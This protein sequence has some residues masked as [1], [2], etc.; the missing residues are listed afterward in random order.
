M[1]AGLDSALRAWDA[2]A[3]AACARRE[4]LGSSGHTQVLAPYSRTT[5]VAGG[6]IPMPTILSCLIPLVLGSPVLLRETSKD[7]VTASLLARSLSEQNELLGSCFESV[8]FPWHDEA[9]L[10]EAL[11]GGCVVATGRDETLRAISGRLTS[12]QRF[13]G[14]GHR[15]SIGILGPDCFSRVAQQNHEVAHETALDIARWDQ[16]GCLSP[17]VLYLVGMEIEER[18]EF[19]EALSTS[20]DVLGHDLPRGKV[21][22]AAATS[23]TNERASARMRSGSGPDDVMLFEGDAHT[24]ILEA[25]A[26]PRPA[27]LHR[28]V[29][30]LPVDTLADLERRL[31]PFAGRLS[32]VAVAG[33]PNLVPGAPGAEAKG[34][35]PFFE[36]LAALGVSRITEPGQLQTPPIDWPH[37][38]MPIFLP[39]ARFVQEPARPSLKKKELTPLQIQTLRALESGIMCTIRL[40]RA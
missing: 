27:P 2:D 10:D 3:F 1:S 26:S 14:Y 39:C 24:V 11:S 25:E 34:I 22:I 6:S 18:R 9:A 12:D 38:G 7:P 8:A 33:V 21:E 35:T 29:R 17:V 40:T 16:L 32:S 15:F 19:A 37:D 4:I 36:R 5:V 23:T 31:T 13:V 30:L 28:F 20:L